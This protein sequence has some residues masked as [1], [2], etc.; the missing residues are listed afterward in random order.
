MTRPAPSPSLCFA[1]RRFGD[2]TSVRLSTCWLGLGRVG[3]FTHWVTMTIFKG[4]TLFHHPGLTL[5]T[6]TR[7]VRRFLSH[8]LCHARTKGAIT[9]QPSGNALGNAITQQTFRALKARHRC[10]FSAF[11]ATECV[12]NMQTQGGAS[13]CPG[14]TSS[15]AFGAKLDEVDQKVHCVRRFLSP[16]AP[17]Q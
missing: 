14:L 3:L 15:G 11:S 4:V 16:N 9:H 6:S 5:G 13:L 12:G 1:H 8:L 17:S 7:L 10:E 2:R